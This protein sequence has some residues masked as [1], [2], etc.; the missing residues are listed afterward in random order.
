VVKGLSLLQ[1][2]EIYSKRKGG[3]C[4]TYPVEWGGF[5]VPSHVIEELYYNEVI[6]KNV[7]DETIIEID[8]KIKI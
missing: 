3:G 7:Y 6:D 8:R 2:M 5:N 4:F 1:L